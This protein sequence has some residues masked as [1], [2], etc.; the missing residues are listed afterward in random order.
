MINKEQIIHELAVALAVKSVDTNEQDAATSALK[1]YYLY[2]Q[3]LED[4]D[5]A[6]YNANN[7]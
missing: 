5:E 2:R 1:K 4:L 6:L 3:E 7:Y